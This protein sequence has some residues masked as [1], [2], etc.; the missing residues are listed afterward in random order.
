MGRW[1]S[2][3]LA[4]QGRTQSPQVKGAIS[5][6]NTNTPTDRNE[7]VQREQG[8]TGQREQGE[9]EKNRQDKSAI[10]GE[11]TAEKGQFDKSQSETGQ[12]DKSRSEPTSR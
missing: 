3:G 2:E 8:Q 1:L 9:F 11:K 10:G 7:N 6:A 5:L 12:V 4:P